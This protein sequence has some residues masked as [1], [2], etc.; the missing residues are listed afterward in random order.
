[1]GL[2][3]AVEKLNKA[4][5]DGR[6]SFDTEIGRGMW[7]KIKATMDEAGLPLLVGPSGTCE[8]ASIPSKFSDITNCLKC[9]GASGRWEMTSGS[10]WDNCV[11]QIA[12]PYS[13][14]AKADS[15][16]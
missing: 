16:N 1:M 3:S 7:A 10:S 8:G 12:V 5:D 14:S 2:R 9:N 13:S 15:G 4:M 11:N 6:G